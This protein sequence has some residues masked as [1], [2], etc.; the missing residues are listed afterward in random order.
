MATS[1]LVAV[2]VVGSLQLRSGLGGDRVFAEVPDNQ[3]TLSNGNG[4]VHL[5]LLSRQGDLI[6][7]IPVIATRDKRGRLE[8]VA[9]AQ[10]S[11]SGENG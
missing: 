4:H 8:T 5:N 1:R 11:L 3:Y 7:R 2:K 9:E 10:R 6:V